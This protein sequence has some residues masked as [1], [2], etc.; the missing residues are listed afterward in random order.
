ML[1]RRRF[2]SENPSSPKPLKTAAARS[3]TSAAVIVWAT[4]HGRA[5]DLE[6][7]LAPV[8]RGPNRHPAKE[9]LGGASGRKGAAPS[10]AARLQ[11]PT[12]QMQRGRPTGPASRTPLVG[13]RLR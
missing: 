12:P 4:R 11:S 10:P 1:C 13:E 6:R 2:K 5:Y 9:T 8:S 3:M 7:R